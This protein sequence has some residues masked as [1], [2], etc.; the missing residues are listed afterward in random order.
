MKRRE[1]ALL[2]QI[3]RGTQG[4]IADAHLNILLELE[5]VFPDNADVHEWLGY[6]YT[7]KCEFDAA[8]FHFK[9]RTFDN[10]CI[11]SCLCVVLRR[12]CASFTGI[13]YVY[14]LFS[15]TLHT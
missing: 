7:E 3:E 2:K 13:A 10:I 11:F 4:P 8:Q 6:R 15:I 14:S 9:V 12:Y 5:A 1:L